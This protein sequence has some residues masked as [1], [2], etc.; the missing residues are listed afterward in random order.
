MRL[1]PGVAYA[2][3]ICRNGLKITSKE[4]RE[5]ATERSEKAIYPDWLNELRSIAFRIVAAQRD[6]DEEGERIAQAEFT[7]LWD[8]N[9]VQAVQKE[10]D[11]LGVSL[12]AYINMEFLTEK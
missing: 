7:A 9:V 6:G 4:K 8:S 3:K 5:M 11:A 10:A 1:A 2:N 12:G